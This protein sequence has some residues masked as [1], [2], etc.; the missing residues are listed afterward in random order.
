MQFYKILPFIGI[1][2]IL[3]RFYISLIADHDQSSLAAPKTK[4]TGRIASTSTT[5]RLRLRSSFH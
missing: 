3:S 1:L 5:P 4:K 2:A